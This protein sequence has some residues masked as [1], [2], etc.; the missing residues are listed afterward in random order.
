MRQQ[1][2]RLTDEA[3][4]EVIKERAKAKIL[5]KIGDE[6]DPLI[7]LVVDEAIRN[8]KSKLGIGSDAQRYEAKF[9]RL[10]FD[11][12]KENEK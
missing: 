9:N 5:E 6:L 4:N 1:M 12:D 8:Y 3:V 7:D 11:N 10:L 2:E